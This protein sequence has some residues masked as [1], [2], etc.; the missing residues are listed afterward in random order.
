M[1]H[2]L[3]GHGGGILGGV[4]DIF[5]SDGMLASYYKNCMPLLTVGV[6]GRGPP[7]IDTDAMSRMKVDI[8][9]F[10]KEQ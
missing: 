1:T 5:S 2:Q 4:Y 3:L 8:S 10:V 7:I 9:K 6:F